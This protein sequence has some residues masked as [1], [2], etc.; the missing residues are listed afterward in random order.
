MGQHKTF[1]FLEDE[2]PT[3]SFPNIKSNKM[4]YNKITLLNINIKTPIPQTD[5]PIVE[6]TK[7]EDISKATKVFF[8]EIYKKQN[9]VTLSQEEIK[10]FLNMDEANS[11]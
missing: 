9:D 1:T 4:G 7:Q 10:G 5:N 11:P 2:R 8:Q 6:T 3:K